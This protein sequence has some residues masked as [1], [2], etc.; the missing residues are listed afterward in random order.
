MTG[1]PWWGGLLDLDGAQTLSPN[2][3]AT[4]MVYLWTLLNGVDL[5]CWTGLK[6]KKLPS[7]LSSRWCFF[8]QTASTDLFTFRI[9]AYILVLVSP[10]EWWIQSIDSCWYRE[11]IPNMQEQSTLLVCSQSVQCVQPQIF[12]A[13]PADNAFIAA[14][15]LNFTL[16]VPSLSDKPRSVQPL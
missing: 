16:C 1:C 12:G 9:S 2:L 14:S 5:N 7:Q 4:Q 6:E 11:L 13:D 3:L 8:T 15:S 10:F